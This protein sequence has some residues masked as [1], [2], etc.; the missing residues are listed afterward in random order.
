MRTG[1][2]LR[3]AV[4]V[5]IEA[6]AA[7]APETAGGEQL[8]G[9]RVWAVARFLVVLLV[10][11]FHYRVRHVEAGKIEQFERPHAEAGTLAQHTVDLGAFGDAFAED[12]Q[13]P[14]P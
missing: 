6:L 10:D 9:Q 12:A 11:R 5:A 8:A 13:G 3:L 7:L 2:V 4:D 1:L 14:V